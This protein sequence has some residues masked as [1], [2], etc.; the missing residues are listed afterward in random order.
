MSEMKTAYYFENVF[1]LKDG[2]QKMQA[3]VYT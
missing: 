2:Y 3:S 1:M